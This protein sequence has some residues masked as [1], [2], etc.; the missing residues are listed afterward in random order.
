MLIELSQHFWY[1]MAIA[2]LLVAV[3]IAAFWV[4]GNDDEFRRIVPILWLPVLV[5]VIIAAVYLKFF[6][7]YRNDD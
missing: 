7:P 5:I 3:I 4:D 2:Y 6:S 1:I